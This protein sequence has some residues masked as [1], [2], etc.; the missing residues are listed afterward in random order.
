MTRTILFLIF[1]ISCLLVKS[2]HSFT[3]L[4]GQPYTP[5]ANSTVITP[6]YAWSDDFGEVTI[7]LPFQFTT[8]L[9]MNSNRIVVEAYELFAGG[10]GLVFFNVLTSGFDNFLVDQAYDTT[11]GAPNESTPAQ[12]G[13]SYVV[14]GEPGFRIFKLEYRNVK[15]FTSAADTIN[16]QLWIREENSAIEMHYGKMRITTPRE[17]LWFDEGLIVGLAR[18]NSEITATAGAQG[19]PQAPSYY[20]Y[21]DDTMPYL[22]DFPVE[23]DVYIFSPLDAG[24]KD[25]AKAP[26]RFV[27][28]VQDNQLQAVGDFPQNLPEVEVQNLTG[29]VLCRGKLSDGRMSLPTLSAGLYQ[30]TIRDGKLQYALPVVVQ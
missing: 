19:N 15:Y 14:E 25:L 22:S 16:F 1:C 29:Q 6:D 27:S 3:F 9:G 13:I 18:Y 8:G 26:F 2:Q 20:Y 24:I 10:N 11:A 28:P 5:I 12:S 21:P 7:T 17:D 23:G 4:T 30:V